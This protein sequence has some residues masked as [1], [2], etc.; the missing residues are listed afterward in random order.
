[1]RN[2]VAPLAHWSGLT[3]V[4]QMRILIVGS[5]GVG[6]AVAK[7]AARRG[8]FSRLVL[9]DHDPGL[10]ESVAV[11]IGDPRIGAAVI[12]ASSAVAVAQLCRVE[13]IT[14]VLNAADPRFVMPVFEGAFAAGADYLDLAMSLSRSHPEQ[15]HRLTGV[16]LGDEQLAQAS[17]W[18][19][20]GRLAL[21]G[22]GAEPGLSDVFARYAA[23]HLFSEI[24]ELGTRDGANL[25]VDGY[26]F[27]RS[28]S[29]WTTLEECLNPP[30]VWE[31]DRGWSTTAPF[32]EPEVFDFPGGIG[33]VECVNVEHGEVLLMPRWIPARRVTCKYGLG[34]RFIGVL[35]T[36]H[37]LGLDATAPVPVYTA[38]GVMA[39]ISPRDLVASCLP[40]PATLAD[41]M[42]GRICA[43]LWANGIGKD[44]AS[45]EVYLYHVVDN[46]WTSAEYGVQCVVWQAAVNPVV[47]LELLAEGVWAG[48]GVLGPEAFDA[49]PFLDRLVGFGADWGLQERTPVPVAGAGPVAGEV[50]GTG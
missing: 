27:A 7:I 26:E 14:H 17:R 25:T 11:G 21:V 20:A 33:P 37:L 22:M 45:R 36:L 42:R 47:A 8:F 39:A 31:R 30:V 2:M 50:P 35:K 13:R 38:D 43:G 10:A 12:N 6:A 19:S 9:A 3:S 23:D 16:K 24:D 46:D 18:E 49:V 44:G 28:L 34:E 29:I 40:S 41:R 5:G 32:S 15:P 48:T 1:M 4:R